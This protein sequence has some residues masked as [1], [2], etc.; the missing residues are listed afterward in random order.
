MA[1][2]VQLCQLSGIIESLPQLVVQGPGL[3]RASVGTPE[4][5]QA[6][7]WNKN[8]MFSQTMIKRGM[9]V[10]TE[11]VA[12]K[13]IQKGPEAKWFIRK[14]PL[15]SD[16]LS[17]VPVIDSGRSFVMDVNDLRLRTIRELVA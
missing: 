5:H 14:D 16:R 1:V 9:I 4:L 10:V 2:T 7:Q 12:A 15:E 3:D 17:P 8:N 11:D 13:E 6:K